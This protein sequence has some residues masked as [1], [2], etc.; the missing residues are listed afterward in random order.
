M[1]YVSSQ[2]DIPYF[3]WQVKVYAN[4]FIRLGIRP[5]QIHAIFLIEDRESQG[6][7]QLK[8]E[9]PIR[10]FSYPIT[11]SHYPPVYK[12]QG[13]KQHASYLKGMFFYH[14]SDIILTAI[15]EVEKLCT[16][17]WY[18]SDCR[19]YI[20]TKYIKSKGEGLLEY[21]CQSIGIHPAIVEAN[22]ENAGGAQYVMSGTTYEFWDKVE[23]DSLLLLK[24]MKEFP[25]PEKGYPIQSFCAEM[26]ATLWNMIAFGK[27]LKIHPELN[28]TF[29]TS[30]YKDLSKVKILHN[31]GVLPQNRDKMFYKGDYINKSPL[32]L[33]FSHLSKEYASW[34]YVEELSYF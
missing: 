24:A 28:F 9:L 20:D 29:A 8:S 10:I 1:I 25:P 21:M 7:K 33:D 19:S 12:P 2:P 22:D 17:A 34:K 5:E 11:K 15:P 6:L 26:W 23:K 32:G 31:A 18:M 13:M 30:H 3:H 27:E 4:N 16:C 14:D